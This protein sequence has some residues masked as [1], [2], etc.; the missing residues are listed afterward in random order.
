VSVLYCVTTCADVPAGDAWLAAGERARLA[1]MSVS[2]RRA[3]FRLGRFA[4]KRALALLLRD[5]RPLSQ[6][7]IRAAHDGAPEAW[8]DGSPLPI[9]LSLSHSGGLALCAFASG[10]SKL[11]CDIEGV[12]PRSAAFVADCLT[13]EE[14]AALDAAA[15]EARQ[16]LVSIF[17]SAKESSLK[18]L[19]TGLR[20]DVRSVTVRLASCACADGWRRMDLLCAP[21]PELGLHADLRLAGYWR[22]LP[23]VVATVACELNQ[24]EPVEL[25]FDND[26]TSRVWSLVG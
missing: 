16:E 24:L 4:A 20:R 19:R 22:R 15:A 1:A 18:A 23:Q 17:W 12:E 6:F 11:G 14:H 3:D 7:E 21:D 25:V 9:A 8:M 5:P 26:S 10:G 2:K 13:T